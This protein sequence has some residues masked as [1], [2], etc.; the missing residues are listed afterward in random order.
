MTLEQAIAELEAWHRR[1]A[2]VPG[3]NP[4]AIELVLGAARDTLSRHNG[5]G[6][7]VAEWPRDLRVREFP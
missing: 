5:K 3:L 2:H 1:F 4:R 6:G 7:D